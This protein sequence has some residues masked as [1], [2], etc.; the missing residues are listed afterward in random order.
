V[1]AG[2]GAESQ[3]RLGVINGLR[4][5]AI[6]WVIYHHIWGAFTASGWRAL[7][8]AGFRIPL[9]APLSNGWQGVTLFFVLSGFVLYLPYVSGVRQMG[10]LGDVRHFYRRRFFRL[11]P[12][13]YV[14]VI[15]SLIFFV[16]PNPKIAGAIREA[17]LLATATFNFDVT[18]YFPRA[19]WVLWSLG[20]EVW[21]SALFPVLVRLL[22]WLGPRKL[23]AAAFVVACITRW[24]GVNTPFD[25]AVKDSVIGRI[26]DFVLG[27]A[28]AWWFVR[29]GPSRRAVPAMLLGGAALLY[30]GFM[31]WDL[32]WLQI[33]PRRLIA[34]TGICSNV[35]FFL[36]MAASLQLTRGL[37]H[38][39]L[40][41]HVLQV[42]GMMCYSLYVWHGITKVAIF[43]GHNV[44]RY[45]PVLLGT[46]FVLLFALSAL[47]YR[48]VEFRHV[49]DW[50]RLFRGARAA[51]PAA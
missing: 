14:N 42:A 39:F 51:R 1:S 11:F 30:A 29:G 35:G 46:Y 3:V 50:R 4:G 47:T 43:G 7:E 16:H 10:A 8:V 22:A 48:Y 40:T 49:A 41:S 28:A 23:V 15:V 19:N 33:W 38:S 44:Q 24:I 18:E 9:F 5:L 45:P 32:A 20:I 17:L 27:M 31:I 12:L 2:A 25:N 13:L 21:F 36:V 6:L 34:F 37:L 26:D